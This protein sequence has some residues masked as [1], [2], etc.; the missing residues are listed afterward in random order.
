M[1]V[2]KVIIVIIFLSLGIIGFKLLGSSTIYNEPKVKNLYQRELAKEF[3][4]D[5]EI[6]IDLV[7][8]PA[9]EKLETHW[10]PGEEF[11]YYL[12][13]EVEIKIEGEHSIIGKPG[14]VG[15]VPFK[16]RHTAIAGKD[17]AKILVFRVH[18]KGKPW[19]YLEE[20]INKKNNK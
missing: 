6:K 11:H 18:T 1:R 3:T 7:E 4:P 16:K 20:N 10:H 14:T 17:G 13:G 12:E 2:T 8:I 9:N 5:R 15:H 19:R